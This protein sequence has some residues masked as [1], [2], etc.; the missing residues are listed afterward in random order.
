[1]AELPLEIHEPAGRPDVSKER[2][3][4]D[5]RDINPSRS[6]DSPTRSD[7][8]D[9]WTNRSGPET[10]ET[11]KASTAAANTAPFPAI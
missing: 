1:M 9:P 2:I 5:N 10:P 8:T 7:R 11:A 4:R 3:S 6:S